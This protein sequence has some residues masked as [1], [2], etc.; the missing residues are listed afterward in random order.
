MIVAIKHEDMSKVHQAEFYENLSSFAAVNFQIDISDI[1]NVKIDGNLIPNSYNMEVYSKGEVYSD[2]IA[3][4][5]FKSFARSRF[6]TIY[7]I[8]EK[9][10]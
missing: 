6:W 4:A 1:G 7:L 10:I 3:S 8:K 2:Y 9:I 5:H